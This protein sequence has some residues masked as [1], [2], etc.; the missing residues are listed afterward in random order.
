MKIIHKDYD[1]VVIDLDVG[2]HVPH[3]IIL[4]C[5]DYS[6]TYTNNT[7][8]NEIIKNLEGETFWQKKIIEDYEKK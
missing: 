1:K 4:L 7:K 6:V 5:N 2:E 8:S 3:Y